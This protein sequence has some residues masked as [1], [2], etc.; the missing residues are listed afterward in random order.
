MKKA[1]KMVERM[2]EERCK[3]G[4]WRMEKIVRMERVRV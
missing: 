2:N 3:V 1:V 4:S